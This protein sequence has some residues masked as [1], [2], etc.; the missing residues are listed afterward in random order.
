[1][2]NRQECLGHGCGGR[3]AQKWRVLNEAKRRGRGERGGR[4]E[5]GTMG[6]A[7]GLFLLFC[8]P[9]QKMLH[10]SGF[11]IPPRSSRLSRTSARTSCK[12]R[13]KMRDLREK[14]VSECM[15]HV[16]ALHWPTCRPVGKLRHVGAVQG[17]MRQKPPRLP[18][19][20]SAF[21][22]FRFIRTTD[23]RGGTRIFAESFHRSGFAIPLRPLRLCGYLD[24]SGGR[25]RRGER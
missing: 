16:P 6:E 8:L 15:G 12:G 21:S 22:A 11:A 7:A 9:D 3:G 24:S 10:R 17:R 13:L 2:K 18:S 20:F 23:A 4:R 5:A 19:A 14:K 25:R 1:M